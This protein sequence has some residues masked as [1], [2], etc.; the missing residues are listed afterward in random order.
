[1]GKW[2]G[3][4]V[5]AGVEVSSSCARGEGARGEA[6]ARRGAREA[7]RARGEARTRRGVRKARRAEGEREARE[8]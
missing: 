8:R 6:R 3:K 4:W 7:W 2:V 1:M 5:G